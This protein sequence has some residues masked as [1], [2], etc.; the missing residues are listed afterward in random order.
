[1]LRTLLNVYVLFLC[2]L[3]DLRTEKYSL[4]L[5]SSKISSPR[6]SLALDSTTLE[7]SILGGLSLAVSSSVYDVAAVNFKSESTMQG[8]DTN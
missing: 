2:M 7:V 8:F 6:S 3:S 5:S 1:M 4:L